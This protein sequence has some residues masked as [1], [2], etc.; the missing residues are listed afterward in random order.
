MV[1]N[2]SIDQMQVRFLGLSIRNTNHHHD[3]EEEDDIQVKM[4]SGQFDRP[5]FS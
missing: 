4:L 5:G 2:N 1:K 3:E